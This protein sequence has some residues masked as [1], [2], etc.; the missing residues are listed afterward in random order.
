MQDLGLPGG[1]GQGHLAVGLRVGGLA[2]FGFQ[3]LLASGGVEF[4]RG[5]GAYDFLAGQRLG[6]RAGLQGP[7]LGL[8]DLGLVA[9]LLDAE[10]PYGF[11]LF[12]VGGLLAGGGFLVAFGGGDPRGAAIAAAWGLP[13]LSM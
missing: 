5:L 7:G 11:S 3:D 1:V 8:V 2:D 4:G 9:G 6:Q 12:G 10:F 13:R